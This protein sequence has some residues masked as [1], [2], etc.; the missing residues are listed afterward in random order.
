MSEEKLVEMNDEIIL[1]PT[2]AILVGICMQKDD[3]SEKE[4]SL[5]ELERLANTA[6]LKCVLKR[7]QNRNRIDGSTFVGKGF[8]EEIKVAAYELNAGL[9]IFDNELTPTQGKNIGEILGFEVT[10]RTEIILNI[11]HRH[12]QTHEASLQVEL[13]QLQYQLPRLK[14]LWSSHFEG[15]RVA[16]SGGSAGG[17]VASRGMGETQLEIDK[18]TIR[19][20]IVAIQKKLDFIMVQ[21]DTQS[22]QRQNLKRVCLVGYTNAGKSTIF[23]QI[24]GANVL[25][26]DKLFATLGS[27]VRMIQLSRGKEIV[28]SDTVGFISQLPHHLVASF[29]AT[30][31]EVTEADLLLH[32][33]DISDD[34]FDFYINEVEKV[35][36]SLG[37]KDIKMLLVFNKIDKLEASQLAL[38]KNRFPSALFVS[39]LNN[40]NMDELTERIENELHSYGTYEIF[41]PFTEQKIASDLEDIAQIVS[42]SY[43]EEGTLFVA[44][45]NDEDVRFFA[46]FV[47]KDKANN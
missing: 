46:Q 47:K 12:A 5:D 35:L 31:K 4:D 1:D 38:L 2:Q 9:V 32:A 6:G 30:L 37:A 36:D 21:K 44:T 27:T 14:K 16:A 11:F 20:Q 7:I 33:V 10:D 41:I 40:D 42:K 24:T 39:A 15:T 13:A 19:N 8:L 23:N 34:R 3:Y 25:V 18:R 45:L 28:L 43:N 22:K 17:G 29:R 26:E